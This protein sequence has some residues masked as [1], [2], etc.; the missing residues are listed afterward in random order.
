MKR[1]KKSGL[2]HPVHWNG[3]ST[4]AAGWSSGFRS[5]NPE[6]ITCKDCIARFL[7]SAALGGEAR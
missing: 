7:T 6:R 3:W 1:K 4:C 5:A 2:K